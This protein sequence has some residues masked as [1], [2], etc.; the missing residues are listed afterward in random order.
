MRTS[1][2]RAARRR[3]PAPARGA[4]LAAVHRPA[5]FPRSR[6]PVLALMG[7]SNVGKSTL[8]NRL[9]GRKVARASREPGKTRGIY[10]YDTD[11][12]HEIADLPGAGFA[13]VSK[14]ARDVWADLV[15]ELF[16]SGRIRL[17]LRLVDPK[18]PRA[19]ADVRMKD[20]LELHG[21]PT[22]AVATKWD[23]LSARERT[24]AEREL[25]DV[26]GGDLFPVSAKTGE[27]IERLRREIRRRME[28]KEDTSHG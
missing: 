20:Y 10:F 28:R 21:I 1:P 3:G 5:D 9:V 25:Q 23:R 19:E 16:R 2:S 15:E 11:Q 22:L 8:V 26:H 13:R 24:R 6:R 17:A 14:Q 4:L 12:G 7:R 27:G 18:V